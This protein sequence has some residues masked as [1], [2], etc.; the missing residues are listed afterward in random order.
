MRLSFT[1]TG[2]EAPRGGNSGLKNG[3]DGSLWSSAPSIPAF[4]SMIRI[5]LSRK[6]GE[7]SE[8]IPFISQ[9]KTHEVAFAIICRK[10]LESWL[11]RI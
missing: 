2:R 6:E 7:L 11:Q 10:F 8:E 5:K 3:G 9:T 4:L 1:Q